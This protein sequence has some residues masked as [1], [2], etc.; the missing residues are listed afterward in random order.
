MSSLH[1][2]YDAGAKKCRLLH[3]YE[4]GTH[5]SRLYSM[6][7][8]SMMLELTNVVSIRSG[9]SWSSQMS[10]LYDQEGAGADW[11]GAAWAYREAGLWEL[12]A[13]GEGPGGHQVM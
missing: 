2:Q 12:Q 10:S 13:Q 1:W 6:Y 4:A 3:Y 9:M 7:Y 8:G 11:P 5:E